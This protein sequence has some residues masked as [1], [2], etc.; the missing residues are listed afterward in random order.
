MSRDPRIPGMTCFS[1]YWQDN[2]SVLSTYTT[3]Y[4]AES[5]PNLVQGVQ[6]FRVQ[7][8][9]G[10]ITEHCTPWDKRDRIISA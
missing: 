4:N 3:V 2:Y 6:W 7:W 10:H 8:S 1:N 9:D 5:S